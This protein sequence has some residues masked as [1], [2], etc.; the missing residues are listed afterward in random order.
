MTRCAAII[1]RREYYPGDRTRTSALTAQCT[2]EEGHDNYH[3]APDPFDGDGMLYWSPLS[4]G[5]IAPRDASLEWP[6]PFVALDA[7]GR[8]ML[9]DT[10]AASDTLGAPDQSAELQPAVTHEGVTAGL[11]A[12]EPDGRQLLTEANA[13]L[14]A[15]ARRLAFVS[16]ER[17]R[18]QRQLN[19][20]ESEL[21]SRRGTT[22]RMAA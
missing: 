6:V 20:A 7:E 22:D 3:R 12:A 4:P 17:D 19:D 14:E 11:E 5:V 1:T 13:I 8:R 2:C 16:A 21:R 18:L 15:L 10:P 9:G